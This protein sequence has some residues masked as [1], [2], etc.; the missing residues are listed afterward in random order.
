VTQLIPDGVGHDTISPRLLRALLAGSTYLVF[1]MGPDGS[2]V[3]AS[4]SVKYLLGYERR[5]VVGR[6]ALD[7]LPPDDQ[8]TSGGILAQDVAMARPGMDFTPDFELSGDYQIRHADGHYIWFEIT[9]SNFIG[10]PEI[11]ALLITGRR[12]GPRNVLMEALSVLAYDDNGNEAMRQMTDYLNQEMSD[13]RAAIRVGDAGGEWIMADETIAP[14]FSGDGPWDEATE[15][16][17]L[18]LADLDDVADGQPELAERAVQSGFT[19]CWCMPLPI[20]QPTAY[21]RFAPDLREGLAIADVGYSDADHSGLGCLVVWT[22][23]SVTPPGP[24]LSTMERVGLFAEIALRRKR[25]RDRIDLLLRYDHLTGAL[26]RVGMRALAAASQAPTAHVLIDLDDFKPVND[27]HGHAV[28]DQLLRLAAQRIQTTM[29]DGDQIVRLGGDEFLVLLP[30]EG[31]E[32]P[33]AIVR[34]LLAAF[35][36]PFQIGSVS[37]R[38]GV[39]IGVAA[40]DPEVRFET[41]TERADMAMYAAKQHGKNHWA[42]WHPDPAGPEGGTV[43][44]G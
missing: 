20:L 43:Q 15:S 25:D 37:V 33:V 41:L 14:L 10:D 18:V 40:H 8:I 3:D 22:T 17:T 34:R 5:D 42:A 32:V 27:S 1:L 31:L 36:E 2:V 7:L 39:S 29:R 9:R 6:N 11:N 28:G 26:S 21:P 16:G 44:L 35:A 19:A 12:I 23:S 38:V 13:T 24:Y 4:Q 30:C